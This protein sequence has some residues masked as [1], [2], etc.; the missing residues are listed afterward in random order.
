[1]NLALALRHLFPNADATRDFIVTNDRGVQAV[2]Q[3]NL[4]EPQP[5]DAQLTEAWT[6]VQATQAAKDALWDARL[7]MADQ[8]A[9]LP[10]EIRADHAHDYACVEAA[11]IRGDVEAAKLRIQRLT[12]LPEREPIRAQ[13]LA[14]FPA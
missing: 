14:M 6:A 7:T 11:L 1:M 2:A 13:F 3:W 4:P 10:A 5:T 8:W 9:A 12:L